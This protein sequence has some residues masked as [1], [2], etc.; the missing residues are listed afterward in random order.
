[1]MFSEFIDV[2][3]PTALDFIFIPEYVGVGS[4]FLDHPRIRF[5]PGRFE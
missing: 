4:G 1:M 5:E 3:C 2:T